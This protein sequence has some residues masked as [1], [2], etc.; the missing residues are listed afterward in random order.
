[1]ANVACGALQNVAR[2]MEAAGNTGD[3]SAMAAIFP[4]LR[5]QSVEVR[6][7]L[8]AWKAAVAP[9]AIKVKEDSHPE[10]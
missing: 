2:Q 5:R 1:M 10:R 9:E 3:L 8:T 6:E 4:E 7:V